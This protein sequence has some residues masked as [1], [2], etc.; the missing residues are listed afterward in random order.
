MIEIKGMLLY[1][2]FIFVSAFIWIETK[3]STKNYTDV[4]PEVKAE[5]LFIEEKIEFAESAL[6]TMQ[7]EINQIE[8]NV[9]NKRK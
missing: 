8:N 3:H 7:L 9:P 2:F 6:D 5:E 4:T 1:F